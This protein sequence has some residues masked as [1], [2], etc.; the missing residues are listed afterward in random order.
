MTLVTASNSHTQ[1]EQS[2]LGALHDPSIYNQQNV[3]AAPQVMQN[4]ASEIQLYGTAL[5]PG[6]QQ[7]PQQ[8]SQKRFPGKHNLLSRIG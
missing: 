7:Q 2:L 1:P 5:I 4:Q 3:L 6:Y 8:R